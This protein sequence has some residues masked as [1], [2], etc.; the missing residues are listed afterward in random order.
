MLP[1][2]P[3]SATAQTSR[4]TAG[5]QAPPRLS[6]EPVQTQKQPIRPPHPASEPAAPL[7]EPVKKH[8]YSA[9]T[10]PAREGKPSPRPPSTFR[11]PAQSAD[12]YRSAPL[13]TSPRP[14]TDSPPPAADTPAAA[15]GSRPRSEERRVGKECR[16]RWSPYH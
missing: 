9:Q 15:A 10:T 3:Q 12:A 8:P 14:C 4:A 1:I 7:L 11:W 2:L 6:G 16:S 5:R 13:H